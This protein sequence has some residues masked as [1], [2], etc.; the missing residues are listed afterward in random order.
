V[1]AFG[2]ITAGSSKARAI[3][4][5]VCV[6]HLSLVLISNFIPKL[7]HNDAF[8]W[9]LMSLANWLCIAACVWIAQTV[10]FPTRLRWWLY[11]C[12]FGLGNMAIV[13]YIVR[14]LTSSEGPYSPGI[15]M[16]FF[17]I[18]AVPLL[19]AVSCEFDK[20]ETTLVRMVDAWL[21]CTMSCFF[22]VLVFSF[23]TVDGAT[24]ALGDMYIDR[25]FD[26]Q[27]F[28]LATCALL[29]L[30]GTPQGEERRFFFL[31][32]SAL[33]IGAIINAVRNRAIMQHNGPVWDVVLD[34]Q[35]L[36]A[37]VLIVGV[38][39]LPGP[40]QR[41]RPSRIL[42]QISRSGSPLFLGISTVL[43]AITVAH[44]HF[45]VGTV[46]IIVAVVAYGVRTSVIQGQL[47]QAEE[48]LLAVKSILEEEAVHD[49]LTGIPNRRGFDRTLEREWH[50][51]SRSRRSL[52]LLM[53]DLDYFKQMNDT[54]GHYEGDRCLV[55]IA[56]TL[57]AA[58]PRAGDF[59]ARYGGEEFVAV[60]TAI[61][62]RG[63]TDAAQKLCDV[64]QKLNLPNPGSPYGH[65]T[66][67]VGVA[68]G[69]FSCAPEPQVL[70][71]AADEALYKAKQ[72][73]RNRVETIDLT[74]IRD[75]C[76]D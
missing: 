73:G 40:L 23:V 49:G 44:F 12:H 34:F 4:A 3:V 72:N 58:L 70:L 27:K 26:A 16:S 24:T 9:S 6:V 63:A 56:R 67:S 45:F 33:W 46:G 28:F 37:M 30:I 13:F 1:P 55:V 43:L 18:S 19:L 51:S 17:A 38:Y 62:V 42:T 74:V 65:V 75:Y 52:A 11:A 15:P 54:Y 14:S 69:D 25:I 60:L 5:V 20:R 47:L 68:V 57:H 7:S 10:P 21:V 22:F 36:L 35:F 8:G 53:I 41:Y 64:V 39:H 76:P 66:V 71:L 48:E 29:R 59:V 50:I 61:D 2:T 32:S 31:A